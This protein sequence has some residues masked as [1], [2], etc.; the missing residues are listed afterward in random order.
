MHQAGARSILSAMSPQSSEVV[1]KRQCVGVASTA[2]L[3]TCPIRLRHLM[4][5]V[6]KMLLLSLG[7]LAGSRLGMR[8][9]RKLLEPRGGTATGADG[10]LQR[11]AFAF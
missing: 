3:P 4:S 5:S 8:R 2:H 6:P 7:P 1:T 10:C 9:K 11:R